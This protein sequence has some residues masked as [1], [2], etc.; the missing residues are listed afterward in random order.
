MAEGKLMSVI[1]RCATR[2][3]G[4]RC[5][6]CSP[7]T[8]KQ[9]SKCKT[10]K[11]MADFAID[12]TKSTGKNSHCRKCKNKKNR[13]IRLEHLEE[14]RKKDAEKHRRHRKFPKKRFLEYKR[15][16]RIRNLNWDL[17][18]EEFMTFW[19]KPCFYCDNIPETIGLDRIDSSK[20]Y[21][22]NNIDSCCI[23]CN[24]AKKER[25]KEDYIIHCC[26]AGV[27]RAAKVKEV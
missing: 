13:E 3:P 16:A 17:T 4:C 25:S 22:L 21:S 7:P 2:E 11:P 15:S 23:V 10:I 18:F 5:E 9:C 20:G 27:A 8:E 24:R 14:Y 19:Q 6:P 12:K 26:R 1:S